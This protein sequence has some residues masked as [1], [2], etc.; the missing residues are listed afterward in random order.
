[1]NLNKDTKSPAKQ[2]FI[3]LGNVSVLQTNSNFLSSA[4]N[5]IQ[6]GNNSSNIDLNLEGEEIPLNDSNENKVFEIVSPI[7][8]QERN[9]I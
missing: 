8:H 1:M 3:E 5:C 6:N 2:D 9:Q 7:K 4:A